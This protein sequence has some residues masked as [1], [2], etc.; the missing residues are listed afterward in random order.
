VIR[1]AV[2]SFGGPA[3]AGTVSFPRVADNSHEVTWLLDT[4]ASFSIL[5][6]ADLLGLGLAPEDF[7]GAQSSRGR[8]V[9]GAAEYLLE[10]ARLSFRHADGAAISYL[11]P[12]WIALPTEHNKTFPSVLGMDFISNFRMTIDIRVPLVE[13]R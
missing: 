4:G 12:V 5:H 7:A 8:G 11:M 6:P 9:G 2:T 10:D 3:I 1:G 13:L